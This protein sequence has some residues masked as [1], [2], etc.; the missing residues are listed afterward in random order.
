M[1]YAAVALVAPLFRTVVRHCVVLRSSDLTKS[2]ASQGMQ[3]SY[4]EIYH[5]G[6]VKIPKHYIVSNFCSVKRRRNSLRTAR[7]TPSPSPPPPIRHLQRIAPALWCLCYLCLSCI[8]ASEARDTRAP[9]HSHDLSR[10]TNRGA[11]QQ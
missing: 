6:P 3:P 7:D 11:Q 9:H 5:P 10:R 8:C 4:K 1:E 2:L